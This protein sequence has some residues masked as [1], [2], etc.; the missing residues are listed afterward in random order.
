MTTMTSPLTGKSHIVSRVFDA[1]RD[2]VWK[3][4]TEPEH[5]AK[6]FA[7]AGATTIVKKMEFR[8]GG[9]CHYC[10]RSAQGE[11]WGKAT[12]QEIQPKDRFVLIQSFSD[13][14][15]NIATHPMAPTWPREVHSVNTFEDLGGGKTRY[16][17]EWTPY[18]AT[19]EEVGTFDAARAGMNEGWGGTFDKLTAYLA[20]LQG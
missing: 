9:V 1:P 2:L 3:V 5:I 18:N 7:P 14:E 6:W 13:A 10:Q 8:P 19:V 15:G 17:V 4:C 16:A 20:G 12:Y 11:V